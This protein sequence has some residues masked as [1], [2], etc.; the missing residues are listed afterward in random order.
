MG[1]ITV[2]ISTMIKM[3]KRFICAALVALSP[4]PLL[5]DG[6]PAGEFAYYVLAL[7]WTPSWCEEAGDDRDAAQCEIGQ[8]FGF[9][10][11][12]LWPQYEDGWPSYCRTGAR[13]PSRSQTNAMADLLGSGGSAWY[14]WKKHGR[15]SGLSAEAYFELV[16]EAYASVARPAVFRQITDTVLLPASVVED[17]FLEANPTFEADGLTVTCKENRI[18]EV[19]ICLNKDLSPRLCAGDTRWDCL[20]SNA[21][22]PPIR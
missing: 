19:R 14:Q 9:A 7:S 11:H 21:D 15:C 22:M 10:V 3:I 1:G 5:A 6:E 18:Q 8:G 2:Y 13:D 4:A 12:G 16:R 20:M 17:A